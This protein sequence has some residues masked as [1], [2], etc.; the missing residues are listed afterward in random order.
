MKR[1]IM[2]LIVSLFWGTA[3]YLLYVQF[4]GMVCSYTVDIFR[5]IR[6]VPCDMPACTLRLIVYYAVLIIHD[7]VI[8]LPVFVLFGMVLGLA[9]SRYHLSRPLLL[10]AGFMLTQGYYLFVHFDFGYSLPVYVELI[11]AVLIAILLI[12]FTKVGCVIK[13]KMKEKLSGV[14]SGR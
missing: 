11:R 10:C 9:V 6:H 7:T 1:T 4:L 2:E 12:I 3:A 14:R 8:G 13:K 5:F